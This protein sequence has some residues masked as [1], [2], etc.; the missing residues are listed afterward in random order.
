MIINEGLRT[1]YYSA[2]DNYTVD[3]LDLKN[4]KLWYDYGEDWI[5]NISFKG[6]CYLEHYLPFVI[7]S[8][9]GAGII[10]DNKHLL[11]DYLD[12]TLDEEYSEWVEGFDDETLE[13]LFE[14]SLHEYP[15]LLKAYVGL[16]ADEDDEENDEEDEE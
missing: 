2:L 6:L 9:K 10:E 3:I 4:V 5:F 7:L 1:K 13:T 16:N 8:F 14:R 12:N 11:Y 15:L